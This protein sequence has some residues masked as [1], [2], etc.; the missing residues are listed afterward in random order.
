MFKEYDKA[1]A[2][3][4]ESLSLL[5][6]PIISWEFYQ[7]PRAEQKEFNEIQK[8][9][10]QK[11][12]F[13][14]VKKDNNLSVIVTDSDF[15][16]VFASSNVIQMNGY[17]HKELIGNSP[18]MF[19]GNETSLETTKKISKAISKRE[20][21]QAIILNYKKN[22]ATYFCNIEAYPKFNSE[23][24]FLNYIAFEKTA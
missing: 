13:A 11:V 23:G 7:I 6:L 22:G 9:W 17:H 21:F 14:K 4:E 10:S 3:Y 24:V 20:P 5:P 18:K 19:Q 8:Y 15:K 16:I 1:W 2:K 12:D